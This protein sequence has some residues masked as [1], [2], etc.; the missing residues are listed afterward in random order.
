LSKAEQLLQQAQSYQAQKI[1]AK[2]VVMTAREAAQ[3]AGDARAITAKRKQEQS[4]MS[5][6]KVAANTWQA[7]P[8][9]NPPAPP[10][11]AA[12]AAESPPSVIQI[13]P[14]PAPASAFPPQAALGEQLNLILPV[15]ETTGAWKLNLYDHLFGFN[16][17]TLTPAGTDKLSKIADIVLASPGLKVEVEGYTSG[18]SDQQLMSQRAAA[19]RDYLVMRGIP[20]ESVT[21]RG[22]TMRPPAG[23]RQVRHVTVILSGQPDAGVSVSELGR[24][25]PDPAGGR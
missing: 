18:T 25:A 8:A 1:N 5:E 20:A 10:Q 2:Q 11:T 23:D 3:A 19:V 22:L 13:R 4:Q 21:A 24:R 14:H 9:A 16:G 7:Q 12:P 15:H 17:A 6:Q